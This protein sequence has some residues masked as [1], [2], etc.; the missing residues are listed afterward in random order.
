MGIIFSTNII[1][2]HSNQ[3]LYSSAWREEKMTDD[4]SHIILISIVFMLGLSS[5]LV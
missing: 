3:L 1:F 5:R 4:K 2:K